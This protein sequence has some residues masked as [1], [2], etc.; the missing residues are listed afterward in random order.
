MYHTRLEYSADSRHKDF[1]VL[2]PINQSL[3]WRKLWN[4]AW[5]EWLGDP[6]MGKFHDDLT[7]RP[8]GL[9]MVRIRGIIPKIAEFFRLVNYSN[10]ICPY[11]YI[12]MYMIMSILGGIIML[13]GSLRWTITSEYYA[14]S[15]G[16]FL[17]QAWELLI[18]WRF[19]QIYNI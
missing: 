12:Y 16:L 3:R 18:V 6:V 1:M 9:I 4:V 7:S 5:I 19:T 15:P 14:S 11:I 17:Y 8:H 13:G 2:A 10:L